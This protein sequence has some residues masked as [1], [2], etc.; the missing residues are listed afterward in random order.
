MSRSNLVVVITKK[1]G[2][3]SA[4]DTT[5]VVM[6]VVQEDWTGSE[7]GDCNGSLSTQIS[8]CKFEMCTSRKEKKKKKRVIT[9]GHTNISYSRRLIILH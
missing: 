3:I 8:F 6:V 2:A 7:D 1:Y 5:V 4:I 9:G